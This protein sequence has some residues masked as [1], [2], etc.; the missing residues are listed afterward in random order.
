[1]SNLSDLIPAGG[2]QNNTDFV[3]SG[4]LP[5]GSPVILNAAGTVTVVSQTSTPVSESIPAGSEVVFNTA[6]SQDNDVSFDPNTSGKFVVVYTDQGNGGYSTAVVGTVSGTSITFGA[7]YTFTAASSEHTRVAFNPN[8]AGQFVAICKTGASDIGIAVIG[9]VTGTTIAFSA[10]YTFDANRVE[11]MDLAFNANVPDE[12]VVAYYQTTNTKGVALVGT[13]SGSTISYGSLVTFNADTTE[14][15]RVSF[16]TGSTNQFVV[17]Y[18]NPTNSNY[19]T[20]VV[21]TVASTV[22]T[23][24][25]VNV[26]ASNNVAATAIS[27]DPHNSGKFVIAYNQVSSNAGKVLVGNVSGTTITYGT[28][29]DVE[30]SVNTAYVSVDFDPSVSNS[31]IIG[32]CSIS[33]RSK[34][35]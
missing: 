12:F 22:I 6:D 13:I 20:S 32:Y 34:G 23:Y 17:S 11:V 3:A 27:H 10:S 33:F 1:M 2:G 5:N 18:A 31:I 4:A 28:T 8:T 26:F 7:E 25:T 19:G 9:T 21:G 30:A 35:V 29:Y 16:D 14:S 24:G 15:V